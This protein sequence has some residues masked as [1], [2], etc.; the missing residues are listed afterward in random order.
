MAQHGN[1]GLK[2]LDWIGKH[3]ADENLIVSVSTVRTRE[4]L[5]NRLEVGAL[6]IGGESAGH[7][8]PVADGHAID[9]K[10]R[11]Q[12]SD[13]PIEPVFTRGIDDR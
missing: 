1:E 7:S 13:S 10:E 8:D 4:A 6:G 2:D 11:L 5:A 3:R 9:K 12:L